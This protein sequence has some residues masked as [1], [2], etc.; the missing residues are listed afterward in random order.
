MREI[1]N[2]ARVKV[3][4]LQIY[5]E[6]NKMLRGNWLSRASYETA[7]IPVKNRENETATSSAQTG[8]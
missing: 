2:I 8:S 6:I 4:E 7:E 1:E 3:V 5:I